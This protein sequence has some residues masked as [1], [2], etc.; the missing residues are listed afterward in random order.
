MI[1]QSLTKVVLENTKSSTKT[2]QP[3]AATGDNF[4]LYRY[5]C[6]P[7][8]PARSTGHAQNGALMVIRARSGIQRGISRAI[9]S[10]NSQKKKRPPREETIELGSR[11]TEMSLLRS[12]Y[13]VS[14]SGHLGD[15]IQ[16]WIRGDGDLYTP[17]LWFSSVIVVLRKQVTVEEF[18][19]ENATLCSCHFP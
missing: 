16:D 13:E 11:R 12:R 10:M 9:T 14:S 1:S 8:T 19:E 6:C 7:G 17:C 4:L 15:R 5:H 3:G 2:G 18:R